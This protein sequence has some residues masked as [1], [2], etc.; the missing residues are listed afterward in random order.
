LQLLTCDLER[1]LIVLFFFLSTE[2]VWRNFCVMSNLFEVLM[3]W[4]KKIICDDYFK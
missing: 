1:V 3:K 4:K 2:V